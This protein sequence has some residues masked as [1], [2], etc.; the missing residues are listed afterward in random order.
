[1]LPFLIWRIGI[2]WVQSLKLADYKAWCGNSQCA[3]LSA[4]VVF[5]LEAKRGMDSVSMRAIRDAP[6]WHASNAF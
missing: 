6:A 5:R 2:A 4:G 3:R 1:M